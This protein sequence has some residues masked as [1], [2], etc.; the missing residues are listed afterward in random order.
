MYVLLTFM[1]QCP[2]KCSGNNGPN[3]PSPTLL[4]I[5]VLS[6]MATSVLLFREIVSVILLSLALKDQQD[7]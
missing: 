1:R 7:F 5:S 4:M 2:A 3:P 6:K